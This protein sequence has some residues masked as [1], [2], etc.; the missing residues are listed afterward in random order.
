[1]LVIP[2]WLESCSKMKNPLR[3]II[4]EENP[5]SLIL[6]FEKELREFGFKFETASQAFG[7]ISKHKYDE[8][9]TQVL[10]AYQKKNRPNA[11]NNLWVSFA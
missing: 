1:M 10:F 5:V 11:Q 9:C 4:C 2:L 7:L 8:Y 6:S 3:S